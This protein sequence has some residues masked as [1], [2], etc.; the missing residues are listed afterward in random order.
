M[1]VLLFRTLKSLNIGDDAAEKVVDAL[2]EHIDMA[3]GQA[4][5]ALEAKLDSIK[6]SIDVVKSGNEQ[7]RVWLIII[8]SIIAVVALAGSI[9]GAV[10]QFIK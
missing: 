5:K 1:E 3:V 2:E 4:N 8:T 9:L 6:A 7:M 10:V